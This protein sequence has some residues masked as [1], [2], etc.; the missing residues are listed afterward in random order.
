MTLPDLRGRTAVITGASR[1]IGA[2]LVLDWSRRGLR[3]GICAR[4]APVLDDGP[5]VVSARLD[6]TD[7]KALGEFVARVEERFGDIDCWVNNAGVLEPIAPLRDVA[8]DDFRR[9]LDV[10][11]TGVFLGT[12][13]YVRHLRARGRGG[14]LLNLSSGAAQSAYAGWSA[15]CAA[16]AG[17]ERLTECVQLEEAEIGLRAHSVAPGVV[18]TAMQELIRATP[19]ERFPSLPRFLA[20]QREDGFNTPAFV[21]ERLLAIAF[22]PE[23]RPESVVVRL[24][25]EKGEPS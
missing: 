5:T 20:L 9:H 8:S 14:V 3:L 23:A 16:K 13:A 12:R 1:G 10:N 25:W 21:A 7:E 2:A 11:L 15:Y 4:S 24:P 6:V 22:D 18:D 19:A 17:V